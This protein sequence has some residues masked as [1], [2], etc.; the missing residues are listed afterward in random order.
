LKVTEF[1]QLK[2]LDEN[3][4]EIDSDFKNKGVIQQ[5]DLIEFD[6]FLV[7][8]SRFLVEATVRTHIYLH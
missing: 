3:K 5:G 2:L 7:E 8:A 4:T 1:G 6:R